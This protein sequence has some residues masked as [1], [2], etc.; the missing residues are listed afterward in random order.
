MKNP[1]FTTI[2]NPPLLIGVSLPYAF[3]LLVL[4]FISIVFINVFFGKIAMISS[5]LGI[6]KLYLYGKKRTRID[7]FWM[8]VVIKAFIFEIRKP[9]KF[10]FRIFSKKEKKLYR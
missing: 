10:I 3:F 1:I 9:V 8:N 7:P 6:L 2:I 5:L 4:T